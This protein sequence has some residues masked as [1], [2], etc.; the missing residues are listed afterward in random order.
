MHGVRDTKAKL[1]FPCDHCPKTLCSPFRLKIHILTIHYGERPYPCK[2][3]SKSFTHKCNL[4]RH[5]ESVQYQTK[6]SCK[7]C[8][9]SLSSK[10]YV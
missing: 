3:C 5:L 7:I 6:H 4:Q 9:L 2:I 8:G 10:A 1:Q